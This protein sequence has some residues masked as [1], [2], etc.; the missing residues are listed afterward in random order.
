MPTGDTETFIAW[1]S[2]GLPDGSIKSPSTPSNSLV[3]K[4]KRIHY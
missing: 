3:P 2:I 1:K 4:L